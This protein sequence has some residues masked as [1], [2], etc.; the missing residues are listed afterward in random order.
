MQTAIHELAGAIDQITE[1]SHNARHTTM[2]VAKIGAVLGGAAAF[3]YFST[4]PTPYR[5]GFAVATSIA[6]VTTGG[7]ALGFGIPI[8]IAEFWPFSGLVC[9]ASL[10]TAF[11][12]K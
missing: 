4:L 11:V 6:A 3:C 5:Q 2:C 1:L 10:V 9:V 8:V 12:K 7:A